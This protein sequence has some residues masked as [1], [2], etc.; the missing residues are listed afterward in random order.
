MN[1]IILHIYFLHKNYT[2]FLSVM[3]FKKKKGL[4]HETKI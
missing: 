4:E 3:V 2:I 1:S